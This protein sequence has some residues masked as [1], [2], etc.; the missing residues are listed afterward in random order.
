VTRTP[1]NWRDRTVVRIDT[2]AVARVVIER[3][4]ASYTVERGDSTWVVGG[5]AT[6]RT[7]VTGLMQELTRFVA[8]GFLEDGAASELAPKRVTALDANGD[9]LATVLFTGEEA[10]LHAQIPGSDLI[11][12]VSNFQVQ[13]IA[14][15]LA[16][17]RPE[18]DP[19]G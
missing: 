11:F 15:E 1:A 18:E 2:S 8:S 14:P 6:P 9:T 17:L 19:G 10:P 7:A 12:E 3:D 16:T 13:R 4:G 5:E